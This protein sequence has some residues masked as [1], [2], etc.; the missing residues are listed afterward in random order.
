[1]QTPTD[2]AAGQPPADG[3]ASDVTLPSRL[4]SL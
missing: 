2:G 3:A 1:M 4:V